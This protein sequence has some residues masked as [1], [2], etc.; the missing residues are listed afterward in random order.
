MTAQWLEPSIEPTRPTTIPERA[1]LLI[2]V[3]GLVD[4]LPP[5]PKRPLEAPTFKQLCGR[6]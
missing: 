1:Q 6:A 3:L 5:A 2:D 4:A